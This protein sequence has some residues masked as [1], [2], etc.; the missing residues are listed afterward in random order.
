MMPDYVTRAECERMHDT[1]QSD[2][3]RQDGDSL[4]N[5]KTIDKLRNHVPPVWAAI[6]GLEGIALGALST[7][8][9]RGH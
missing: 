9:A 8:V 2:Q 4:M 6:I 1:V 5:R 7:L 3:E